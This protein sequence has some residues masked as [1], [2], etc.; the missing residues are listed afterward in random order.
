MSSKLIPLSQTQLLDVEP[1]EKETEIGDQLVEEVRTVT[2]GFSQYDS[3]NN[4][5]S[6]IIVTA[7]PPGG[8][9]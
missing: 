8:D 4:S 7:A 6:P 2:V 1:S 3:L 5:L 9:E